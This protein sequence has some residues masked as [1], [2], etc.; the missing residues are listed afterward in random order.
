[1]PGV[2]RRRRA[3]CR[4]TQ[5]RVRRDHVEPGGALEIARQRGGDLKSDQDERLREQAR[6][7][8]SRARRCRWARGRRQPQQAP[9][10][11]PGMGVVVF[12]PDPAHDPVG[13]AVPLARGQPRWDAARAPAVR[14]TRKAAPR[15]RPP[16]RRLRR[17]SGHPALRRAGRR[18]SRRATKVT[19]SGFVPALPCGYCRPPAEHRRASAPRKA[20]AALQQSPGCVAR[21]AARGSARGLPRGPF[22]HAGRPMCGSC[23]TA[24]PRRF[25]GHRV[26]AIRMSL[27]RRDPAISGACRASRAGRSV[28]RGRDGALR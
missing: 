4:L 26:V 9:R 12:V 15:A 19:A 13:E 14:R 17:R 10:Q 18:T 20:I 21:P 2:C 23:V 7:D 27:R 5:M 6:A 16:R 11:R 8:E 1:M 3:P 28:T 24:G 22:R 25:S